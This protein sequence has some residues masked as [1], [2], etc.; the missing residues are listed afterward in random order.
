[1]SARF[2]F[3]AA[4]ASLVFA[5][6]YGVPQILQVAG[7]LPTPLDL[8]LIFLPSLLLAPAFVATMAALHVQ[9][10]PQAAAA[11][12][13][14][15]SFAILYAALVCFVYVVQLGAVIPAILAG[16]PARTAA[17]A[18][19]A[20][21]SPLTMVDLLGYT[22]MSLATLCSAAALRGD[23]LERAARLWMIL[24]GLLAP[25]LILQILWPWLIWA[26]ALWLVT[27]PVAMTFV[28]TVFARRID[29]GAM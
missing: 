8:I 23:G 25:V 14:G 1:M 26:G 24:N 19:C 27:F 18:C 4:L 13:T 17:F 16:D 6:G 7:L 2:G 21:G 20:P 3:F 15:L 12:L 28:M 5:V 9:A 29:R 22:M 10:P 11:S